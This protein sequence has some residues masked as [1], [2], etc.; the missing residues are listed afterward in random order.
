VSLIRYS[1]PGLGMSI[2]P[3]TWKPRKCVIC[4]LM[5]TKPG[6]KNQKVHDGECRRKMAIQRAEKS[7]RKKKVAAAF[8]KDRKR[9]GAIKGNKPERDQGYRAWIRRM[10]CLACFWKA[11]GWDYWNSLE[12]QRGARPLQTTPT[13]AAHTGPHGISQKA[14]DRTCIP[15]CRL[16]HT[17]G[18]DSYHKLG[19][20]KF[21]P[22]HGIII[23]KI[24]KALNAGYEQEMAASR[25]GRCA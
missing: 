2:W 1:P 8:K 25:T 7:E 4:R 3:N 15:L 13:E 22:Q 16:H 10:P 18:P 12:R 19:E 5:I 17:E 6:A 9:I 20:K 24:V 11:Q 21:Q 23:R 14:S